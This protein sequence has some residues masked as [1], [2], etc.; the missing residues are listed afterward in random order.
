ML[1]TELVIVVVA[2][3]MAVASFSLP[4][5]IIHCE[6]LMMQ[7]SLP[8]PLCLGVRWAALPQSVCVTIRC[9]ESWTRLRCGDQQVVYNKTHHASCAPDCLSISK[10]CR[11][12]NSG[13]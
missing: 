9:T 12:N 8:L 13:Q 1:V 2:A 3:A 5:C 6:H 10:E 4:P 7:H 11:H